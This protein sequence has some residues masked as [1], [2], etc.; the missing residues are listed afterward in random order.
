MEHTH[1]APVQAVYTASDIMHAHQ[2][3]FWKS[4]IKNEHLQT[5]HMVL[6]LKYP[7][8]NFILYNSFELYMVR[9]A[10]F[11]QNCPLYKTDCPD[12]KYLW[13]S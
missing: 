12:F 2:N 10:N 7:A 3:T 8:L 11:H 9:T 6:T 13:S 1:R 4:K 5:K